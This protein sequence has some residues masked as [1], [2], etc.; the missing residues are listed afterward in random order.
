MYQR[1]AEWTAIICLILY[2]VIM[3]LVSKR[4]FSLSLSV[5]C[6]CSFLLLLLLLFVRLFGEYLDHPLVYPLF[7]IT[8][9]NM[10][11]SLVSIIQYRPRKDNMKIE[12]TQTFSSLMLL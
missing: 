10:S 8:S 3:V 6:C 9:F 12:R 1:I 2:V 5:C 11:V 4:I 7:H